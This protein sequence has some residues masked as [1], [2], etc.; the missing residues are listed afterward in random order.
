MVGGWVAQPPSQ[1]AR[2]NTHLL[3]PQDEHTPRL[4][5]VPGCQVLPRAE[6]LPILECFPHAVSSGPGDADVVPLA[7]TDE[8]GQL[9]DLRASTGR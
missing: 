9:C 4:D 8:Q 3:L 5:G 1:H 6:L 2:E 7:I